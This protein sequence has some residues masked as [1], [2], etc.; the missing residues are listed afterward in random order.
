MQRLGFSFWILLGCFYFMFILISVRFQQLQ[1]TSC[2]R[3]DKWTCTPVHLPGWWTLQPEKKHRRNGDSHHWVI[4]FHSIRHRW[5]FKKLSFC[6]KPPLPLNLTRDHCFHVNLAEVWRDCSWW[7]F[8]IASTMFLL[9]HTHLTH[10]TLSLLAPLRFS[11]FLA[12]YE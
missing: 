9:N 11:Q 7:S 8:F 1:T 4:G 10:L 12:L 3:A 2:R 5:S 6:F